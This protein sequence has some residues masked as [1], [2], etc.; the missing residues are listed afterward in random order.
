MSN[1]EPVIEIVSLTLSPEQQ[2]K[3][4]EECK[5]LE[6]SEDGEGILSLLLLYI[7][8]DIENDD[9]D[10][11]SEYE[12]EIPESEKED[13]KTIKQDAINST[14]DFIANNEAGIKAGASMLK[15]VLWKK[16]AQ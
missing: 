11:D 10:D 5:S 2:T 15:K 4:Y 6:L 8:G 9:G 3:I 12:E 16:F 13:H 14:L 1:N 7:A